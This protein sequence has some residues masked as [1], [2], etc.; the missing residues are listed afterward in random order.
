MPKRSHPDGEPAS[1]QQLKTHVGEKEMNESSEEKMNDVYEKTLNMMM[2]GARKVAE[3]E[4][5]AEKKEEENQEEE[6]KEDL[7]NIL[8]GQT[9]LALSEDGPK[10]AGVYEEA[11]EVPNGKHEPNGD[12]NMKDDTNNGE[13]SEQ[14]AG[15][16]VDK[17]ETEPVQ[18]TTL[19]DC[20]F[21]LEGISPK[22]S[23]AKTEPS[24]SHSPV[25]LV[26]RPLDIQ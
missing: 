15:D 17:T 2:E 16:S 22:P 21:N 6:E 18:K 25:K 4:K 14:G 13:T 1:P 9:Y 10:I 24:P 12:T 23:P 19:A 8:P 5:E 3:E 11:S 26:K 20:G 7:E